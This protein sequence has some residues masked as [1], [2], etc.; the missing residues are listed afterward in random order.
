MS[1]RLGNNMTISCNGQTVI[2]NNNK[3]TG[4]NNS[5]IGNNNTVVGKNNKFVGNNNT[6]KTVIA[7]NNEE[8][9]EFVEGPIPSDLKFDKEQTNENGPTCI[10]CMEN[11]P[12]CVV[13][14]CRHFCL[15]V[16]CTRT[17]L[18][19]IDGSSLTKVGECNCP[20]CRQSVKSIERLHLE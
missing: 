19:G 8:P 14:P 20:K 5:I 12:N 18:F 10:V 13:M 16:K 11:I 17:I 9:I 1:H 2:G 15:C 7:V 4:D 6:E 3:I